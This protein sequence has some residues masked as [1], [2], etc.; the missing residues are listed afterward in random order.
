MWPD[1]PLDFVILP[2]DAEG[3]HYGLFHSG[4]MVSVISM[5]VDGEQ[6]QFRK[7]AT[8]VAYQGKGYGSQLLNYLIEVAENLGIKTLICD[9]RVTAISFYEKFGMYIN[10]GVF[11]KSGKDYV[12]MRLDM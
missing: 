3:L 9:A 7:F 11:Q 4:Q 12:R 6:A 1:K 8:D 10:S 5:F 2:N